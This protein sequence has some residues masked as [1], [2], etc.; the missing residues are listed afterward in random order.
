MN[1]KKRL[2]LIFACVSKKVQMNVDM[3]SK[4]EVLQKTLSVKIKFKNIPR[5]Y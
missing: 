1:E 2:L 5:K 3:K 4:T